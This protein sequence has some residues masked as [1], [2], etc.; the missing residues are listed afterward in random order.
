MPT[1]P[2]CNSKKAQVLC[3]SPEKGCWIMYSC[4][5]CTFTWRSTEPKTIKNP[6]LYDPRF[7]VDPNKMKDYQVHPEIAKRRK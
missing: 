7:R 4:P 3:E 5:I 6:I 2:R 1:C